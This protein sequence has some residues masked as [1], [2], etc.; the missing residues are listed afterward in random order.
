MKLWWYTD[1]TGLHRLPN[2][3]ISLCCGPVSPQYFVPLANSPLRL[4]PEANFNSYSDAQL[5]CFILNS[6]Y[7]GAGGLSFIAG[8]PRA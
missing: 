6:S 3:A 1:T 2:R 8:S 7:Q 4:A 5:F